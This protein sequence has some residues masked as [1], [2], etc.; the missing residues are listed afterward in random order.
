MIREEVLTQCL[1]E[2]EDG[3]FSKDELLDRYAYCRNELEPVLRLCQQLEEL[4]KDIVLQETTKAR[5]RAQLLSVRPSAAPVPSL[6]DW[7]ERLL[8]EGRRIVAPPVLGQMV[9]RPAGVVLSLAL[10]FSLAGASTVSAAMGSIPGDGLY[11][12]KTAVEQTRLALAVSDLDKAE[13]YLWIASSRVEELSRMV[14]DRPPGTRL[15]SGHG[16]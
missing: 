11:T 5:L 13:T 7:W 15:Q 6:S 12:V 10:V 16:L 9:R 2:F 14:G 3:V 1:S 4:P 8:A